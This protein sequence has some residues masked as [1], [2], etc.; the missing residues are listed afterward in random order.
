MSNANKIIDIVYQTY[1]PSSESITY[2]DLETEE[3]ERIIAF[4]E[5]QLA[6]AKKAF[7]AQKVEDLAGENLDAFDDEDMEQFRELFV[8]RGEGAVLEAMEQELKE[9]RDN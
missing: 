1:E 5:E 2:F 4:L 9:Q 7:V 6:E 8:E 3:N